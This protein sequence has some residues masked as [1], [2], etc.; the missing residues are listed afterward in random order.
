MSGV[1][2]PVVM[3]IDALD[4]CATPTIIG[5]VE[6]F[7]NLVDQGNTGDSVGLRVCIRAAIFHGLLRS[8]I[9]R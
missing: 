3:F 1:C 6:F 9:P 4:E 7:K 5:I 8:G 2:K